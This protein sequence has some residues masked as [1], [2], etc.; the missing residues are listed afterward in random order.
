[1]DGSQGGFRKKKI[2]KINIYWFGSTLSEA[3]VIKG[4]ISEVN[5]GFLEN[6][7]ESSEMS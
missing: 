5:C 1:M 4:I 2:F 3:H 6:Q 7:G